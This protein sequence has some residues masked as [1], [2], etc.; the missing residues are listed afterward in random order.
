MEEK[1]QENN[2]EVKQTRKNQ[3]LQVV[4]FTL[5]SAGAAG[6]QLGS[7]ALLNE[8]CLLPYWPAYL[9]SLLLSIIF[10]FTFNR[11]VTFGSKNNIPIAFSKVIL[12]YAIFTPVSTILGQL[13]TDAGVNEY[14]VL[15]VTMLV[16]FVTEFL[17]QKFF[18]FNKKNESQ[19][20][21]N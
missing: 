20:E 3:I 11:K 19:K 1:Q 8:V 5:F 17:Y 13:C 9:I 21:P 15:I 7:F 12:F 4:F 10:N 18:V 2:I 16:N 6:I 14:I